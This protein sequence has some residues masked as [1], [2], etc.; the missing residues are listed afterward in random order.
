MIPAVEDASDHKIV[1]K[2]LFIFFSMNNSALVFV[3]NSK[4]KY[5]KLITPLYCTLLLEKSKISL[6]LHTW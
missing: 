1:N 4:I 3:K 6:K 2:I 5:K